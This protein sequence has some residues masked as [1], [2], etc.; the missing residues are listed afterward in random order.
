MTDEEAQQALDQQLPVMFRW[1]ADCVWN[2]PYMVVA[3]EVDDVIGPEWWLL[4]HG[5]SARDHQIRLARPHELLT[6]DEDTP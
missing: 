4:S 5:R 3:R 2:G 1:A 6:A